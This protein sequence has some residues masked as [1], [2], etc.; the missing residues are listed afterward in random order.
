MSSS[1]IAASLAACV[2]A[3]SAT[4]QA[5][6]QKAITNADPASAASAPEA[7]RLLKFDTHKMSQVSLTLLQASPVQSGWSP[8]VRFAGQTDL[9]TC[10]FHFPKAGQVVKSGETVIATIRCTTPWQLY[11]NGLSFEALVAGG[12]VAEGTLR[13]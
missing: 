12:K 6:E 7:N 1:S 10:I 5:T 3:L 4:A 9:H 2:L 13:P 8:Q 11:D